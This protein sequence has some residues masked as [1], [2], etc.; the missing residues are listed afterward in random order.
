MGTPWMGDKSKLG[1]EDSWSASPAISELE[2]C[3]FYS[4]GG[5]DL[6]WRSHR[7][8]AQHALP[9]SGVI[10]KHVERG[11][12]TDEPSRPVEQVS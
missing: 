7:D 10:Y 8:L 3:H 9:P 2:L 12:E 4:P 5:I 1:E 6:H 11:C